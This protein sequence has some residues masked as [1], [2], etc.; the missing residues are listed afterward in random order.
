MGNRPTWL[1]S[2]RIGIETGLT[3]V[4]RHPLRTALTAITTAVA[5]AVTVNVI[6]LVQGMDE[7]LRRDTARFGRRTVDVSRFPVIIPGLKQVTLGEAEL[8]EVRALL[9]DLDVR[10][11]DRRL[12]RATV[13]GRVELERIAIVAAPPTYAA[14][15]DVDIEA[16]RWFS[17]EDGRDRVCVLDASAGRSLFPGVSPS[18]LVGTKI[19]VDGKAAV[20]AW[21]IVGVLEDPMT[22]RALFEAFD[23][24]RD[25]RTLTSSLL[26]F[27]NVYVPRWAIESETFSGLSIVAPSEEA[28]DEIAKRLRVVWPPVD[29]NALLPA[30]SVGVFVRKDW[31]DIM[32]DTSQAGVLLSNIVWMIIVGVAVVMLTTL[33]LLTIRERYD[34]LAIRRVEG[35]GREDVAWQITVEGTLTAFVGGLLGLPLGYVGAAL[36]REIVDFPFRFEARY[37]LVATAVAILIGLV[38]SVLPARHAASLQ[39]AQVLGRRQ[40]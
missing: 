40:T 39:P 18:E 1:T 17:D 16:G 25:A 13:R 15:L 2:L 36:L 22:H 12:A 11:V 10:V 23:E 14:T 6:S 30:Q 5:I 33:S 29:D 8:A 3:Q 24:G 27:R 31:M 26:S 28:V 37:A 7:D 20:G 19:Q 9:E 4:L 34:E 21:R 35:A 32:G 38:A